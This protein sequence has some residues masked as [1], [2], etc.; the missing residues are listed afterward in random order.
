MAREMKWQELRARESME[1]KALGN[2]VELRDE[3]Y[4]GYAMLSF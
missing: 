1:T 2:F 3:G 4:C